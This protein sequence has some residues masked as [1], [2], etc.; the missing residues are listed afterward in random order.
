MMGN[1]TGCSGNWRSVI[2]VGE[3]EGFYLK[4]QEAAMMI[5]SM[6]S[7]LIAFLPDP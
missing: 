6:R 7:E 5:H 2:P 4:L 1:P 3:G